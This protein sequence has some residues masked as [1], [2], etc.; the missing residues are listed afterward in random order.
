MK[1]ALAVVVLLSLPAVAD[2]WSKKVDAFR[3]KALAERKKLGLDRDAKALAAKYPTP[4]VTF[5]DG[6]P[7][8]VVVLCPGETKTVTVGGKLQPGS[9]VGIRSDAVEVLKESMTAK[10]WEASVRA[11]KDALP[12]GIGIEVLAPVSTAMGGVHGLFIGCTHTW[13]FE[14]GGDTLVLKTHF[15]RDTNAEA[16]GEWKRGG[17][18][19]GAGKFRVSV[20]TDSISLDQD[21]SPEDAMRQMQA[22]Q[23]VIESS[24]MKAID[25]RNEV[26]MKK[27][28]ACGKLPPEK[29]APCFAGPQKELEQIAKERDALL[30]KA[31]VKASPAFGCRHLD[32]TAKGGKLD[33]DAQGCSGKRSQE[34]VPV[35]GHYTA[36]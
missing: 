31:E 34:R 33:G 19:V 21:Q 27:I 17:K 1:R 10:G 18:T 6:S 23:D 8:A 13:T 15:E 11:K 24:G 35:T 25:A 22:M 9:F 30:G 26:A 28:E 2:D 4:E 3:Q 32:V 12:G 7:G 20:G 29:M 5:G 16:T 14:V 36:P